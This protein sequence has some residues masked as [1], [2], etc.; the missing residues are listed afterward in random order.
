MGLCARKLYLHYAFDLWANRWRQK[1][2]TGDMIIGHACLELSDLTG[3]VRCLFVPPRGGHRIHDPFWFPPKP[4]WW[5]L[6]FCAI[7]PFAL[8]SF[9]FVMLGAFVQERVH[10]PRLPRCA[11]CSRK[12]RT[13][14]ARRCVECGAT[15]A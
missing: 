15:R 13:R 3:R 7:F 14:Q 4:L 8:L 6:G 2:A 9:P 11:A 1:E 12:L 5:R 10:W